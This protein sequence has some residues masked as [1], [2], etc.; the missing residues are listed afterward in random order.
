MAAVRDGPTL[1]T[2]AERL[3]TGEGRAPS[4]F[5][6][7]PAAV[8]VACYSAA[9]ATAWAVA[10]ALGADPLTCDGWLGVRGPGAW[11]TSLGLGL[12]LG[13]A[14]IAITRIAVRRAAWAHAL[15]VALRPAVHGAGN[16]TL[17]AVATA[18]ATGEELFFRGLLVPLVGVVVAS[19]LFG[20]LH[21]IRG[22]ARWGWMVWATV[23]G[24]LFAGIFVATGSLAGPVVAHAAINHANLRFLRDNDP[25]PRRRVLGGLLGGRG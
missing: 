10:T 24:L 17:F 1:G 15:H 25:A 23:M 11:L 19:L 21:Q 8:V 7:H 4:V 13:A 20:A 2:Q 22:P 3:A 5:Q 12:P 6:A 9:G 18:S 14:T 16:V